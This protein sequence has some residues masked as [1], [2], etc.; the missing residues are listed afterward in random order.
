M[1]AGLAIA[2]GPVESNA[3]VRPL[4]VHNPPQG[5]FLDEWSEVYMAGGKVGYAHST[6]TRK[7]DL[8]RTATTIKMRIGRVDQPIKIETVQ[9]T[10]ET[11][12]GVPVFFSSDLNASVLMTS[13]NVTVKNGRVTIVSSQYGM[14]QTQTF[15]FSEKALMTWGQQRESILRGFK[16]GT[17][18]ELE[19]YAPELRLDGPVT[20]T[21]RVGEWEEFDFG[22]KRRQG[23]R[24]TVVMTTPFGAME[25]TSWVDKNGWPLKAKVPAPGLGDM[26]ILATDQATALADFVPPEMFLSTVIEAKQR[27]NPKST[28]LIKYRIRTT[29]PD[30][31]L[32]EFPTTG[33]QSSTKNEDGSI[34]LVIKRQSHKP[35]EPR[36]LA[37]ADSTPPRAE[38]LTEY[39]ERNLMINTADPKLIELAKR[40]AGGATDPFILGDKLR[41]FVTDYVKTKSLNIGF[42]TASE[43]CRTKEGDCSE[44]GVLLA[45]LG[46]L[47]KLPS[48]VVVGLVYVPF[49]GSRRDV[50]GYHLWTQFYIDG[51]W[52][53]FDAAMRETVCSPTHIAFATSSLKHIGLADLSLHLLS[54]IGAIDIDILAIESDPADGDDPA[55]G[56][57]PGAQGSGRPPRRP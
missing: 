48:R 53:D 54:K 27:I 1:C 43:V 42:A 10:T 25:L 31:E 23:Q 17:E 6:M 55:H 28:R 40:A 57:D 34:E 15:D 50:F 38:D 36:A 3:A 39:L 29:K 22:K 45:A 12:A 20:A 11:L 44:H 24:V 21:T 14:E 4:D 5:R 19:V 52:I 13:M 8:I 7:G 26:V 35:T 49:L 51:R 41:R 30:V 9:R 37:R 32:G 56:D 2:V 46:R 47:N 18:Y 16:P 33:M